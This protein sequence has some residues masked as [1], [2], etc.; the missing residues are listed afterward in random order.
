[1]STHGNGYADVDVRNA[2]N[3]G[4]STAPLPGFDEGH[5]LGRGPPIRRA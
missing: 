1:M 2:I 5:R 4:A 3:E